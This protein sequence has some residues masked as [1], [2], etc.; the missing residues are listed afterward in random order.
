MDLSRVLDEH[1]LA[2]VE[3][4]SRYLG[5]EVNSVRKDVSRVEVRLALAFPDLYDV[6]LG[7]LGLHILYACINELPWAWAERVYAPA[8]DMEVEL[9][10]RGLPL[11]ALESRDSLDKFDGIGFTL[12][13]ELTFTNI[14]NILDLAGMP[15]RSK[16]RD[17][18]H[19][20][21]FAGGPA[22][23]NPEPLAPFL[24]F[25]VI[26]DGESVVVEIATL[27]RA[28]KGRPKIDKLRALSS[29]RACMSRRCT[30]SR[31]SRTVRSCPIRS[32]RRSA[33]G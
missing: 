33:S 1:V 6:G 3:K 15:V 19:P 18:S 17:E 28:F 7:N 11:F 25:F 26:G 21:T 23:F 22:V 12:Q 13:S 24:D 4:P 8:K 10:Q 30:R 31:R 29:S 20:L 2:R 27:L 16:D 5:N 32:H 9:R 14:L